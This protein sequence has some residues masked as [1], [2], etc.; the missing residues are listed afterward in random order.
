MVLIALPITCASAPYDT[1]YQ[2]FYNLTLSPETGDSQI[3][4]NKQLFTDRLYECAS[5]LIAKFQNFAMDHYKYCDQ[6]HIDPEYLANCKNQNEPAKMYSWLR[7]II[8]VTRGE[9]LWSESF[10]DSATILGKKA[11]V[12]VGKGEQYIHI[13]KTS[14][15]PWKPLMVCN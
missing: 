9:M 12:D 2:L 8:P 3:E 15:P 10:M 13:V 11:M 4:S 7:E 1:V 6:V 14:V 5:E